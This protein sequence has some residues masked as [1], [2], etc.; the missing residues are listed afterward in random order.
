MSDMLK[1]KQKQKINISYKKLI[2]KTSKNVVFKN[3]LTGQLEVP[4]K[5]NIYHVCFTESSSSNFACGAGRQGSPS[6]AMPL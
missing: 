4:M 2:L 1:Q 5:T 6:L 3:R